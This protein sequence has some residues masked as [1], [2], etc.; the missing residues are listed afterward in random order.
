MHVNI[1]SAPVCR[2]HI[3]EVDGGSSR[4]AGR[5][6]KPSAGRLVGAVS[7]KVLAGGNPGIAPQ[8]SL[9][10]GERTG[11]WSL[12]MPINGMDAAVASL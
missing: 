4:L 5:V 8:K 1:E 3:P 2:E 6:R 9:N 11:S 12:A 10:R 7:R